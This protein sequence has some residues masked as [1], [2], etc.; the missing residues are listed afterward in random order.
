MSESN[1]PFVQNKGPLIKVDGTIPVWGVVLVGIAWA[2]YSWTTMN[3]QD[4]RLIGAEQSIH[5]LRKKNDQIDAE[6]R[7]STDLLSRT[8]TD[9]QVVK[10]LLI[11]M[12]KR[13]DPR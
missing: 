5:E 10:E 8:S 12:E 3:D 2:S 7:K 6:Q 9:V 1:S 13:L 11:R 4:K